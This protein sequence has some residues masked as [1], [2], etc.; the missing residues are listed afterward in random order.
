MKKQCIH[1]IISS[2]NVDRKIIFLKS[3]FIKEH[4][5]GQ[6]MLEEVLKNHNNDK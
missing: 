3:Q 5:K 4:K 1:K 2:T 6:Q